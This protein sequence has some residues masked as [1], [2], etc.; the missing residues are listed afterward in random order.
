MWHGFERIM[1]FGEGHDFASFLP[2]LLMRQALP[3]A[4]Y[5]V[6]RHRF[7]TCN[8]ATATMLN[9]PDLRAVHR[10]PNRGWLSTAEAVAPSSKLARSSLC[11]ASS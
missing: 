7:K 4:K 3:P 11:F 6:L 1:T 8:Q 2:T 5:G 10:W 9:L